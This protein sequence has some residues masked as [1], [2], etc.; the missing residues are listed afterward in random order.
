MDAARRVRDRF[1]R[2][3]E[4]QEVRSLEGVGERRTSRLVAMNGE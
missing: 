2:R 1:R 3:Q 4:G